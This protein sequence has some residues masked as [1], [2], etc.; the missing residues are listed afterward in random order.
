MCAFPA[1]YEVLFLSVSI[2]P[3]TWKRLRKIKMNLNSALFDM[4]L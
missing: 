2:S 4:G 1:L 3:F